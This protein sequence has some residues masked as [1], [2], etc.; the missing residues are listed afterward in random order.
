MLAIIITRNLTITNIFIPNRLST[1]LGTSFLPT[2]T[3]NGCHIHAFHLIFPFQTL[4]SVRLHFPI[5]FPRGVR[6]IPQCVRIYTGP[7]HPCVLSHRVPAAILGGRQGRISFT[8][9]QMGKVRERLAGGHTKLAHL[10][11]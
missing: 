2:P 9:I 10:R 8:F 11:S 7:R 5:G 4:S 3:P 1:A 6:N